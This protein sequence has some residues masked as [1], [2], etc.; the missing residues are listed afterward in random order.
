MSCV[1]TVGKKPPSSSKR[2]WPSKLRNLYGLHARVETLTEAFDVVSCRAFASLPDFVV[3]SRS[4]LA[5][6]HGVGWP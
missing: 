1:D 3:W 5:A 2:Q 6:S 4:A